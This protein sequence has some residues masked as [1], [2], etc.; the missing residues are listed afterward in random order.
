MIIKSRY[1]R[2]L[3]I[4]LMMV[5]MTTSQFI[6]AQDNTPPEK[7]INAYLS[8]ARKFKN[9]NQIDLA[10]KAMAKAAD[11]A[12]VDDDIKTVID[13][14]HEISL[15][16]LKLGQEENALWYY[17][18]AGVSLEDITYP[19]G[20]A[21]HL[22]IEALNYFKNEK[23]HQALI[24]LEEAKK[25]N[26]DRHLLNGISLLEGNISLKIKKYSVAS[27]NFNSLV[28]NSDIYEKA[29]L[30]TKAYL[31]LAQLNIALDSLDSAAKNGTSA[32]KLAEENNFHQEI[33]EAN[34]L[35]GKAYEKLGKYDSAL[36]YNRNLLQIKDSLLAFERINAQ[37]KTADQ[38]RG[39]LMDSTIKKQD[40]EIK[41]LNESSSR[42]EITAI[43]TSAFLTIISLLAVSLYRNN[44]IKLKTNDLLH[45]KNRE[46]QSARDAAVQSMEAKTNFLS[47]VSH[48]L[49]TPLYAVTG[50]THLLLEENPS[51]KQEEHLEALKFSGDYL[52]NFINDILQ[53]NKIDADKMEPLNIEFN[54]KKVLTEVINSLQQSAKANKTIITLDYDQN[55]PSH[56]L[57]DPLKLSQIFINLVG[58]ALKF[59]KKGEVTVIT[60]LQEQ[61]ED[62]VTIYFEIKDT[63]IGIAP[64]K[65]E[66]IFDSF[67][68]GSIQINREYGGTGLGL[69]IVKSLIGLFESTIRLKSELGKG[70]SFFFELALKTTESSEIDDINFQITERE[71][72]LTGLHILIVE[73]NKINQVITKK[74]LV[75]KEVTCDIASN[76]TDAIEMVRTNTYDAVLMDIHM[77]GISGEE[78]TIEIRKFNTVLPIIALTAIS[79]DDSLESFYAAGV[80]DVVTK[81]FKPEVF[82]QK[83][84]QNVFS[85]KITNPAS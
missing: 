68:Q 74:M 22:Y 58:N 36:I 16:N 71:Y 42:S 41:D 73:D 9:Q 5:V 11:L 57:S 35:L 60:K 28:V 24:L 43:L 30:T 8:E 77:P 75:K 79:L 12:E 51:K 39:E 52:L 69:T 18:R 59:T 65:Q 21:T 83:I 54:L 45:T 14:Y 25:L 48:E 33:L 46:L 81:P 78:A 80:N 29:Y 40:I 32:L 27:R 17:E 23:P 64:E 49:R 7:D 56:L 4:L 85:P 44:Q 47:T 15:L 3:K 20:S 37:V 50:L 13:S 76:G 38:L 84:G 72:D 62:E 6:S 70:S 61:R 67:E 55:I 1:K 26:N 2:I 19:Q 53:I 10:L 31:G 34:E 82:Y 63:G 66:N